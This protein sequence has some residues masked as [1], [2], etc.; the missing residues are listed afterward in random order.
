M[1]MM[2]GDLLAIRLDLPCG[3]EAQV[4]RCR[5][6]RDQQLAFDQLVQ[7]PRVERLALGFAPLIARYVTGE[8]GFD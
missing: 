6:Q 1:L 4:Q 3:A 8:A 7:R 2:P 5:R